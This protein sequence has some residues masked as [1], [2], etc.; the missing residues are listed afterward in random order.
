MAARIAVLGIFV[1]ELCLKMFGQGWRFFTRA[2]N[3]F[4]FVIVG[5]ALV[6]SSGPLSVLRALRILRRP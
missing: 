2:W 4:D 1:V 6:P 3:L 5:V